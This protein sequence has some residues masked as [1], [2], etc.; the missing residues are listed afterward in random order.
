MV[1]MYSYPLPTYLLLPSYTPRGCHRYFTWLPFTW[2][3][4][5]GNLHPG[6]RPLHGLAPGYGLV[7]GRLEPGMGMVG[8]GSSPLHLETGRGRGIGHGERLATGGAR[9]AEGEDGRG[10][11]EKGRPYRDGGDGRS[12]GAEGRGNGGMLNG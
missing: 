10:D 4:V 1:L 3:V 8:M 2:H 7:A 5:A 12:K 6:C 11:R 9:D